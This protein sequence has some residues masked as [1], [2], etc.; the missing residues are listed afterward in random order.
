MSGRGAGPGDFLR[1]FAPAA[2]EAARRQGKVPRKRA[3]IRAAKARQRYMAA[4]RTAQIEG[5]VVAD[6]GGFIR[7]VLRRPHTNRVRGGE[8]VQ[9][10]RVEAVEGLGTSEGL[11]TEENPVRQVIYWY[12]ADG[13]LIARRDS[14]EERHKTVDLVAEGP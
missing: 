4:L 10:L 11:F 14:W 3:A 9:V 2:E 13:T 1:L 7:E 5:F 12:E 6:R 8:L